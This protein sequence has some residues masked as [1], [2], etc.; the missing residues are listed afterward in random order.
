MKVTSISLCILRFRPK[1]ILVFD[2]PSSEVIKKGNG[3]IAM[4]VFLKKNAI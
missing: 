3:T 1:N 2:S 4:G